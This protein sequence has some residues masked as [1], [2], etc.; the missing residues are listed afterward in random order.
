MPLRVL[1]IE[2]FLGGSHAAFAEGL[3]SHSRHQVDVISL[4]ARFWKW[5]MRGAALYLAP[6]IDDIG[7]YAALISSNM[8][9]LSDFSTLM[10]PRMPPSLLYFHEDQLTYPLPP[11]ADMDMQFG[12]TDITSALAA[13]QVCFNSSFHKN[14]FFQVLP[15]FIRKMPEFYP[16]WVTGAIQQKSRVC[17]PGVHLPGDAQGSR[18]GKNAPPLVVWNHRW[19]FDK[20]PEDFFKALEMVARRGVDFRLAILGENFQ[21]CPQVFIDARAA[22]SDRIV[23]YGYEKDR[24]AYWNWLR[25]GHVVVSTAIQENFGMSVIEA[26]HCGCLPL[27]PRRLSYPEIIPAAFHNTCLYDDMDELVEKLC[28]HLSRDAPREQHRLALAS[29]MAGYAWPA[30]IGAYDDLLEDIADLGKARRRS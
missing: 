17:Y 15:G 28:L 12:F 14:R 3:A 7:R 29:A 10:G 5:R 13:S 30:A 20:K 25:Q 16:D 4:P 23:A 6:K 22:F 21:A 27:L 11:G 18:P 24:T 1:F 2:P 8:M 19:E 26:I 9:S